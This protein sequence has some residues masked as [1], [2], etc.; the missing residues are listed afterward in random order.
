KSYQTR[1]VFNPIVQASCLA[2]RRYFIVEALRKPV[3]SFKS[4]R[5]FLCLPIRPIRLLRFSEP[6]Q[7]R[8]FIVGSDESGHG[9]QLS[10][11]LSDL[12]ENGRF[13]RQQNV[14]H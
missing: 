3:W 10:L 9:S 2:K 12:L 4:L 6:L 1:Q 14:Q 7:K 13:I 5:I 11:I 8:H